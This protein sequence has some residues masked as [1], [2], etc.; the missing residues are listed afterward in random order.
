MGE[1]EDFMDCF[2]ERT[3]LALV[4]ESQDLKLVPNWSISH[5]AW[6]PAPVRYGDFDRMKRAC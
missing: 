4:P 1:R 5:D 3:D 6:R 2:D